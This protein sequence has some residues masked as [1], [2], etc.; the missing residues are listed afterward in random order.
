M[1]GVRPSSAK[2]V[3]PSSAM[4]PTTYHSPGKHTTQPLAGPST[5]S[6]YRLLHVKLHHQHHH[7]LIRQQPFFGSQ[8]EIPPVAYSL[9]ACTPSASEMAESASSSDRPDVRALLKRRGPIA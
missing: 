5:V 6:K 9:P 4:S 1:P 2:G 7:Y 3:R 8:L